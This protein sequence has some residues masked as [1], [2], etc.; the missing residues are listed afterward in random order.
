MGMKRV[1]LIGLCA[2]FGGLEEDTNRNGFLKPKRRDR[3]RVKMTEWGQLRVKV[4]YQELPR[5]L[6]PFCS[7]RR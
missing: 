6:L 4:T 7:A 3:I 5:V 2:M 1:R